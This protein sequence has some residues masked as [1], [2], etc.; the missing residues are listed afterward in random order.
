MK[1][2]EL[3]FVG[4]FAAVIA[5]IVFV[6][7]GKSGGQNGGAQTANIIGALG[8]ALTNVGAGL[9]TGSRQG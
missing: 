6:Q 2:A 5:G 3:F 9:E 8:G 4:F 1:T 7:A